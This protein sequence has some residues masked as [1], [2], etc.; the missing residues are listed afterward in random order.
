MPRPKIIPLEAINLASRT[1][2]ITKALFKEFILGNR[3]KSSVNRRWSDLINSGFFNRHSDD[4]MADV[5]LL[6][7]RKKELQELL[8]QQPVPPPYTGII[9]HDEIALRGILLIEDRGFLETWKVESEFKKTRQ[10]AIQLE[11][12]SQNP[13][14]PDAIL[15]FKAPYK[16][17]RVAIEIELTQKE[18]RRYER[19]LNAYSFAQNLD[20]IVFVCANKQIENAIIGTASKFFYPSAGAELGIMS[21]TD[22][23]TDPVLGDLR[24]QKTVSSL[25]TWIDDREN[26]QIQNAK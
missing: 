2:F 15:N 3:P 23:L 16:P 22:W 21:K 1:G 18:K 19:I 4:R 12:N 9:R 11:S 6:N 8:T 7:K 13:K 26:V 5:Y 20:L 25:G 24:C 17:I 10:G 14:F